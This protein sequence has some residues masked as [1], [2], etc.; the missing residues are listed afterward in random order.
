LLRVPLRNRLRSYCELLGP[1]LPLVPEVD[2]PEDSAAPVDE[3]PLTPKCENTLCRHPGDDKS[4]LES[5]LGADCNL[6]WSPVNANVCPEL[7]LEPMPLLAERLELPDG[8]SNAQGTAT[9]FPLLEELAPGEEVE[10]EVSAEAVPLVSETELLEL[11]PLSEITA[12][13]TFPDAG[14]ISTSL[15]VP[16][17]WPEDDVMLALFRSDALT[18]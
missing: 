11:P 12:K 16:I 8:R 2:P 13:S 1:L 4:V 17:D 9:C 7:E 18:S 6:L 10:L 15:M 5:K 3:L 14:L